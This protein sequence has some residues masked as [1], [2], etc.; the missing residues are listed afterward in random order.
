MTMQT[1]QK[2]N[3]KKLQNL[4]KQIL[5]AMQISIKQLLQAVQ[6]S[7]KRF[8]KEGQIFDFQPLDIQTLWRQSLKALQIL[9][10]EQGL[11][12][13]KITTT[14]KQSFANQ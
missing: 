7:K 5:S 11:T 4:I 9:A 10:A 14:A 3:L 6:N 8:L 12:I 1:F 2:Q 13:T